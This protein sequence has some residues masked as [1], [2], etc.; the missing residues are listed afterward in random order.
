MSS[1]LS[2]WVVSDDRT[3]SLPS[4][5]PDTKD[6]ITTGGT[7][8]ENLLFGSTL[9]TSAT[10]VG[11][12]RKKEQ[13]PTSPTTTST[14]Q[15][16]RP[17]PTSRATEGRPREGKRNLP[18][19]SLSTNMTTPWMTQA[20]NQVLSYLVPPPPPTNYIVGSRLTREQT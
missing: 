7:K 10:V 8:V 14:E 9:S 12:T 18:F 17:K 6:P 19:H 20:K 13:V 5:R 4:N 2:W 1:R 16:H 3:P 11:V 15:P